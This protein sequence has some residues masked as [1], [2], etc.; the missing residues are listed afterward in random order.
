[1]SRTLRY[2]GRELIRGPNR[3]VACISLQRKQFCDEML[4][5]QPEE[6]G[7]ITEEL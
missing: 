1:M 3:V 6:R 5:K 7:V 4:Y 2:I